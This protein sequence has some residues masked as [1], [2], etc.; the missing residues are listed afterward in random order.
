MD[1]LRITVQQYRSGKNGSHEYD[2]S[3]CV[4]HQHRSSR[5][6]GNVHCRRRALRRAQRHRG[7]YEDTVKMR[8]ILSELFL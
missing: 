5:V 4:E 2:Y 1:Y 7:N 8:D 3:V 6:R